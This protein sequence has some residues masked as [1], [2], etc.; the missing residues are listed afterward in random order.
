M[1]MGS[2][3]YSASVAASPA[4]MS[5]GIAGAFGD[6]DDEARKRIKNEDAAQSGVWSTMKSMSGD[7]AMGAKDLA[8]DPSGVW[9]TL[10]GKKKK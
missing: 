2:K 8:T 9:A 7:V 3:K 6:T 5:K 10:M 4:D 1:G